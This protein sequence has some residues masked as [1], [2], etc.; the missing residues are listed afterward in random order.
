MLE[1][2]ELREKVRYLCQAFQLPGVLLNVCPIPNGRIND[3]FSATLSCGGEVRRY[4]VQKI[5]RYVF[6]DPAAV[7]ENIRQI[8]GHLKKKRAAGTGYVSLNY[9]DTAHGTNYLTLGQGG[10]EEYWRICDFIEN[11]VSFD[12][13]EG[14]ARA[15]TMAGKAFGRFTRHLLDFDAA[16]LTETIPRF[17]DTANRLEILFLAAKQDPLGRA[18][19]AQQ[20][21]S[22][23][24]AHREFAGALSRQAAVGE[25]PLRVTHNDAKTENVLL[26]RDTLEPLAVIDLDTCMPG[27]VCYDF[28]DTVRSGA[29]RRG[30]Q[31]KFLDLDLVR[32]YAKGYLSETGDFLTENEGD[33]LADGAA[34]ITLELA[35]R[36]LTD[37]L[38]GDR[39]FRTEAPDGNL[40]R[41]RDQ[42]GLFRD[43]MDRIEDLRAVV[44]DCI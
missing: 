40:C 6:R 33:S 38:T 15:L 8:T 20:E 18:K 19:E 41:A 23:I 28:G 17:H 11:A 27:L 37:Y 34:V 39:Y 9:Y 13:A 14:D 43:M 42:L 29:C 12:G 4:L 10:A 1:Q 32:A 16:R 22:C 21:L 36:F 31:G 3:S 26:D 35:A 30:E 25:L 44:R 2:G 7:M 5:N 24:C